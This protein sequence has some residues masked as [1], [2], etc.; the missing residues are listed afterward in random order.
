MKKA[1]LTALIDTNI[2]SSVPKITKI[3]HGE[4]DTAEL[5]NAYPDIRNEVSTSPVWTIP[6]N[7]TS[8]PYGFQIIK[9]GRN[10]LF[11]GWFRAG[12][13][14]GINN[15]SVPENT[16]WFTLN[17]TVSGNPSDIL[18]SDAN[19]SFTGSPK[20]YNFT[21]ETPIGTKVMMGLG[22]TG[23]AFKMF[24]RQT[25]PPNTT[26]QSCFYFTLLMPTKE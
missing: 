7:A 2:T 9:Q 24:C 10:D 1:T 22:F 12:A 25:V 23:G 3:K 4:V 14:G 20:I 6:S 19:D 21:A 15:S 18:P 26:D 13:I 11:I 16:E 17:A 8:R 5:E